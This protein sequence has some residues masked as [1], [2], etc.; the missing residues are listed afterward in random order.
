MPGG[1]YGTGCP[2]LK[3]RLNRGQMPVSAAEATRGDDEDPCLERK[4]HHNREPSPAGPLAFTSRKD[5]WRERARGGE[6]EV[7]PE[8]A[9]DCE[10]QA[11]KAG[12][13]SHAKFDGDGWAEPFAQGDQ[14]KGE[15]FKEDPVGKDKVRRRLRKS[16]KVHE[17]TKKE[18]GD[19]EE[20][21][22]SASG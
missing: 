6:D 19:E 22:L 10:A 2:A 17:K 3:S 21:Q 13:W 16:T 15:G 4:S 14:G 1:S 18:L 9:S 20:A 12:F 11:E 7:E 8:D 5:D